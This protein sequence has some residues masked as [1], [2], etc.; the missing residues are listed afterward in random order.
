MGGEL[1]EYSDLSEDKKLKLQEI[2]KKFGV[3]LE[4][5]LKKDPNA[6]LE[7]YEKGTFTL[8]NG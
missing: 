7:E 3:T 6:I 4:T 5:L 1:M 2:A 8:L